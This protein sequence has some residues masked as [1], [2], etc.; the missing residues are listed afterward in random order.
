LSVRYII[1]P[2]PSRIPIIYLSACA[3]ARILEG[4]KNRSSKIF[5]FLFYL[6]IFQPPFN[7]YFLATKGIWLDG[8]DNFTTSM[9]LINRPCLYPIPGENQNKAKE[10]ISPF[11]CHVDHQ[12]LTIR[13]KAV[14]FSNKLFPVWSVDF[15]SCIF[16]III[17]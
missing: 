4:N 6:V 7:P 5:L 9:N 15:P 8:W 1:F 11:I 14:M 10:Y 17:N 12:N 16:S 2:Y 3:F 13:S